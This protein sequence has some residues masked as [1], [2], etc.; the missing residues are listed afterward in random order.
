MVV[1]RPVVQSAGGRTLR[2]PRRCWWPKTRSRCA[3]FCA[4]ILRRNGYNVL[5]AQN[6]GEAL[7]SLRKVHGADP[8]ALTDVVMPRMSGRELAER[9]C[10]ATEM[11][12]LY[13][14]GYTENS[15]VH[16]GVL[17][18]GVAFLQK[19]IMPDML[20]RKVRRFSMPSTA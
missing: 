9:S 1:E 2:G 17:D 18:S 16:H 14:S 6:G 5:E 10:P 4:T 19:P 7:L 13:V 20:L 11:T 12:V 8:P 15:I 3:P